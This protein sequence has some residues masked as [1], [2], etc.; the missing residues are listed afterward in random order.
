MFPAPLM[1]TIG[2]LGAFLNREVEA[3]GSVP[4]PT[5]VS[6]DA[7]SAAT[8]ESAGAAPTNGKLVPG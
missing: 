8:A 7:A 5:P 4:A 6:G 3:A 2:E 1:S